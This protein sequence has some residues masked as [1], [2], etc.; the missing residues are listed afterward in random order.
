MGKINKIRMEDV[1]RVAKDVLQ[2]PRYNLSLVGPISDAQKGA[3]SR[4]VGCPG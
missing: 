1:S 2:A 4:L 3:L